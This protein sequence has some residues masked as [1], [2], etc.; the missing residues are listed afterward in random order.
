MA[1]AL[2]SSFFLY[3]FCLL[4]RCCAVTLP[5]YQ[6]WNYTEAVLTGDD[7]NGTPNCGPLYDIPSSMREL[8]ADSSD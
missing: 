2:L 6:K 3:F 5:D 7:S 8:D 1:K 4:L